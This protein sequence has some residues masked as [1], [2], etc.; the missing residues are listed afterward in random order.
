MNPQALETKIKHEAFA[1][2]CAT[3]AVVR[4]KS[5]KILLL[6]TWAPRS[7]ILQE[8]RISLCRAKIAKGV[9]VILLPKERDREGYCRNQ[10]TIT[11]R[12]RKFTGQLPFAPGTKILAGG[13]Y[14]ASKK[15]REQ[16]GVGGEGLLRFGEHLVGALLSPPQ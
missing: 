12:K 2:L 3:S 10:Y 1:L 7:K 8:L 9:S 15:G 16:K 5:H 11:P 14:F 13:F 6:V 4:T